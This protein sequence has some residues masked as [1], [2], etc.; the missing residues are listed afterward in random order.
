MAGYGST[1]LARP[2]QLTEP[3][4]SDGDIGI[5]IIFFALGVIA[6]IGGSTIIGVLFIIF[7]ALMVGYA[8]G[9]NK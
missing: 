6:L 1:S 4:M 8:A 7:A 2:T 5:T 9:K 3:K